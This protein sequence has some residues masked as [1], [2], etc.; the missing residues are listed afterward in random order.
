[1]PGRFLS[2]QISSLAARRV[3][4][5]ALVEP[6]V[7]ELSSAGDERQV[8]KAVGRRLWSCAGN[9]P[10]AEDPYKHRRV[11][12]L[13]DGVGFYLAND[14]L[15]V[16]GGVLEVDDD[17]VAGLQVLELSEDRRLSELIA[18]VPGHR[19]RADAARDAT[20]AIPEYRLPDRIAE[21]TLWRIHLIF[22]CQ[23]D[24]QHGGIDLE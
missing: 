18:D 6:A 8:G 21:R 16:D 4:D 20:A 1:M 19:G 15:N 14:E 11:G 7:D 24:P 2:L 12:R 5:D 22:R 9:R 13:L 17:Q 10:G 23:S 3:N